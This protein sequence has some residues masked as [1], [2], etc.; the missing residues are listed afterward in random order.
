MGLGLGLLPSLLGKRVEEYTSDSNRRAD[1]GVP[2]HGLAEDEG[3]RDC[4]CWQAGVRGSQF[5][6]R[7]HQRVRVRKAW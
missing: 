7:L 2:L 1:H 6:M 5:V 3:G 4:V